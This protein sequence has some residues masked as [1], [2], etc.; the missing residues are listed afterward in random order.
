MIRLHLTFFCLLLLAVTSASAQDFE[1]RQGADTLFAKAETLFHEDKLLESRA[2]YEDFLSAFSTDSRA[3]KAAM[4]LG[5]IDFKS[6]SYQSA[7]R[8]YQYFLDTFPDSTLIYSVKL[9][10]GRC[11]FEIER[12]DEAEKLLRETVQLNPDPVQKWKGFVYLGYIDDKRLELEKAFKKFKQIMDRSPYPEIK[13][14]AAGY[15]KNVVND[16]LNKKQLVSLVKSLGSVFPADLIL[17]KLIS[18][19]RIER[20][21]GNY[22]ISM[23]ELI[24]R[25]PS[26]ELREYY[27]KLLIRLKTDPGRGIRVGV[28]LPLSGKRAIV[29]Q[30]VLQGI[31]L[32]MNQLGARDKSRLELVVK[33]SGL[34]REVAQVV[35]ELAQDPNVIGIIGP[36]LTGDVESVIPIIEKYQLPIF[37][38]TASTH[39]L[40]EKSPYI[41]RN[42]LTKEMQASFL[43]RYA[44]NEL[45][46]YRFVVIYPTAAYGETMRKV[47]EDEVRS[48]GGQ[49]VESIPFERTQTDFRKQIL[50]IGGMADDHLKARIQRHIK[51]GTQPRPLNDKG[52]KSRPLVEGGLYAD[53]EVEAL[54]VALELNYDAI[55]IPGSFDKVR[56]IVPQLAFYNIEDI[57]LM[58]GNGWH[59]R[60][61]VDAA[62]NYL[63][64][65]LF[66]DGFYVN[67]QNERTVKFVDMFLSTFGQNPTIHSAQSYDV[68]NIFVKFIQER[69]FNRLDVLEKLRTLKDYPGVSGDTSI[70]PSGDSLKS[71][72]RLTVKEGDIAEDIPE[73]EVLEPGS[74]EETP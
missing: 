50:Q 45:N 31:Q 12:Y 56:L 23:E 64:N 27:E 2:S 33:D 9:D 25:F 72:V 17:Q 71:L 69:A 44:V 29:G 43:A 54:K 65:V 47:F 73:S 15:I 58:G 1:S 59:S 67:S 63:K 55:F 62:R 70:L 36:V 26:H 4:R 42:A 37:T 5:Q 21:L 39:G 34:G 66:V 46:L 24:F 20:D 11:Y 49:V 68:A 52:I 38:P 51:R 40:G 35:E 6:K 53:D 22:Q 41:F 74:E 61:L 19:Y 7:L 3:S 28:V 10:M 32:A 14:E 18:I 57:L 48:F 8:Q 30:R 13:Q 60:E 16:K